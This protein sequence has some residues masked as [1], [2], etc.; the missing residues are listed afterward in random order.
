[1]ANTHDDGR[2]VDYDRGGDQTSADMILE[3]FKGLG[4]RIDEAGARTKT[5]SP[6]EIREL[7]EVLIPQLREMLKSRERTQWLWKRVGM[8]LLAIPALAALGQGLIQLLE[9]IRRQ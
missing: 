8:F 7:R 2:E 5:L 3:A 1:V 4:A 9:W 6:E